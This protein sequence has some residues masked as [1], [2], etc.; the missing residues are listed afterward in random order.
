MSENAQLR[1]FAAE[2]ALPAAAAG[3]VITA[4]E[5]LFRQFEREGRCAGGSAWTEQGGR[6]VLIAWDGPALSGCS[7]DKVA[8]VLQAAERAHGVDI[9]ASPPIAVD[10]PP[11][12]LTRGGVRAGLEAGTLTPDTCWWPLRTATMG[13]WRKGPSTLRASGLL[14][15][16]GRAAP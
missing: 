8:Q 11:R 15:D 7:H 4:V 14:M 9:L 10:Q 2:P 6:F 5:K 3:Q 16:T 12:L 13:E 1:I